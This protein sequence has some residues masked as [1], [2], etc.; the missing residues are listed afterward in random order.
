[1]SA[2]SARAAKSFN[3]LGTSAAAFGRIS[4]HS[5]PISSV[6]CGPH[7]TRRAG[8]WGFLRLPSELSYVKRIFS[9]VPLGRNTGDV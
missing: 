3:S 4:S 1:M 5:A 6:D 9:V 7:L 8:R 2:R